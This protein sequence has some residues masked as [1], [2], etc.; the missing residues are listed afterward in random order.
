[1]E[2]NLRHLTLPAM[3]QSTVSKFPDRPALSWEDGMPISYQAANSQIRELQNQLS[4][5]GIRHGDRVALLAANMPNWGISYFAIVN[6]GAVVV[7]LLPEYLPREIGVILDHAGVSGIIVSETLIHKLDELEQP[8]Q[9]FKMHME[10]FSLIGQAGA[11]SNISSENLQKEVLPDDLAAIIYTSGTTGTPKGVMLS[12]RNICFNVYQGKDVQPILPEDRFLSVLPLAHTYECTLG[13]LLAVAGGAAVYY[14]RKPPVPA[15]LLPALERVKPTLMLTVP[16]IIEKIYRNR[17]YPKFQSSFILRNAYRNPA[18]RR[19]LNRAAGR[20]LMKT[21][22]GHLKFF[23]IGGAKLSA[24][25]EQFLM[26]AGFPYAIGYG[27][28]E[29]APLIAGTR[30]GSTRLQSTG[31]AVMEMQIRIH[32]PDPET[33]QGEIW[34]KGPNV[35][36]GYYREPGLTRE[37]LTEDG[38]LK[39]GDLGAFDA[40]NNLYIRGRQKNVIIGASGE[41][42]YPEE[43]E[44][45]IN[46]FRFVMESIVV[47]QK[48]KLVALVHFNREALEEKYKNLKEEVTDY[49]ER[50]IEELRTELRDYVNARVNRFSRIH[51]VEHHD[52]PF[53][54]TATQKIKRFIYNKKVA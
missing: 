10:D 22:G 20:K 9:G 18:L 28:T 2:E 51:D 38:W 17:I 27:M 46:T 54:K 43:I 42:I 16:L 15:V 36:Q 50:K 34:A 23:G 8:W 11:I 48:G 6:M 39:T 29:A 14:L 40:D 49:M 1:M 25:V 47:E 19:I 30:V 13:L 26:E 44:S 4:S 35:M 12:H 41:N 53:Q 3:W 52:T 37:V 21:F 45:V 5:L 24:D 7:P 33:G 32:E 31:P